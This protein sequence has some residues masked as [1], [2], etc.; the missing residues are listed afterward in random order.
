[1]RVKDYIK[2]LFDLDKLQAECKHPDR[3]PIE[4]MAGKKAWRCPDCGLRFSVRHVPGH[5]A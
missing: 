3:P 2:M 1:M 5:F 4:E